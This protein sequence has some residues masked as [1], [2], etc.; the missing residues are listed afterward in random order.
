MQLRPLGAE[1]LL[2]LFL[3]ARAMK[4]TSEFTSEEFVVR[5]AVDL[6]NK[7]LLGMWA[8]RAQM[9]QEAGWLD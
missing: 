3:S 2:L 1:T 8:T 7:P 6:E 9:Q 4:N 5:T